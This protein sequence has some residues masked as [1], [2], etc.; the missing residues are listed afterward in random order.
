[1]NATTRSTDTL[2]LA[3]ESDL[4]ISEFDRPTNNRQL[5]FLGFSVHC[6]SGPVPGLRAA[7]AA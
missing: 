7:F 2:A 3:D 6:S 5:D 1:M 4:V